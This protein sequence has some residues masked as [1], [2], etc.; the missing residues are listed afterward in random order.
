MREQW[1]RQYSELALNIRHLKRIRDQ[2][3]N[4]FILRTLQSKAIQMMATRAW[5]RNELVA[6]AYEWV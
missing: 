1:R 6:S 2:N 3:P 5:I 4:D